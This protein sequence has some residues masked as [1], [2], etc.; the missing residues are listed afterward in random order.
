[1]S[2]EISLTEEEQR[3]RELEQLLIKYGSRVDSGLLGNIFSESQRRI[4]SLIANLPGMAYR[5]ENI[6]N[7]KMEFVSEGGLSVTGYTPEEL[8]NNTP[9]YGDII[10][11]DD[12]KRVWDTVKNAVDKK[13]RY[14]LEYRIYDREGRERWVWEQGGAVI[15]NDMVIFLEGFIMDITAQKLVE[16][17]LSEQSH[18]ERFLA[19]LIEKAEQPFA[20]GFSDGKLGMCNHAFSKLTGYTLDELKAVDWSNVLTPPEWRK[21]EAESLK[22]L[23]ETKKQVNYEKEYVRKDGTRIPVELI[24]HI[25]QDEKTGEEYYYAFVTDITERKKA[26][27]DRKEL[28]K[29]LSQAQ[30]LE[31]IGRLAGGVAHD[32][33][34]MLSV[35]TG[36]S[37]LIIESISPEDQIYEDMQEIYEAA[38]HSA[39]ITQQLLAF[40]RK[41]TVSPR[42]TDL[43]NT[44]EK[45][46][47]MIR[48]LIGED[49]EL[50]W[51]PRENLWPVKIDPTQINQIMANL[52]VNAR[53][54]ISNVGKITIE[55]ET[56]TFDD[57]Y[58]N[59]HS[60]CKKGSYVMIAV[61]DNGCGM[62]DR[63]V[64]MVFEPFFTTKKSGKGTG[65]GLATVYGI[66][67]QNNGFINIYSEP[68]HGTTIKIYI[69]RHIEDIESEKS[70]LQGRSISMGDS[71][72]ILVVEDEPAT[73]RLTARMLNELNYSTI[74]SGSPIAAIEKARENTDK[75]SLLVTDVVMPEMNGKQLAQALRDIHPKIKVL[76]MSGYTANVIAHRGILDEGIHF[77]PKPFTKKDLADKV[78]QIIKT[79][80]TG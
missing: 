56:C 26:E 25:T 32:Y 45:I 71:E 28:Q 30:K 54:S 11:P 23:Q 75:I 64:D 7:W 52:C 67:K 60:D 65:L 76:Y 61:S 15:E 42:V 27:R 53:D 39:E 57:D 8:I 77:L 70:I 80:E 74:L 4:A 21:S 58:C 43:N 9:A 16:R 68:E 69:P 33:N 22:R 10:H 44:I 24:V 63:T 73:L 46:L 20:I 50:L 66:V 34:N 6:E 13:D 31:S 37:E 72:T 35:I 79:G 36:Y 12:S 17:K 51:I 18:R 14:E 62:D 3:I 47:K 1:M 2:Q 5:C 41:Q 78:H 38:K 59:S 55:T 49:I 48:R 40:A 19:D 29:Q